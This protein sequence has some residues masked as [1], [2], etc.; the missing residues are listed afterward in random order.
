MTPYIIW[1]RCN[2]SLPS[3]ERGLKFGPL[4]GL[5]TDKWSLPSRERG[6]KWNSVHLTPAYAASLPSRE[7]GLK[8]QVG[9]LGVENLRRSLHGS[10][11]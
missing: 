6:L 2:R 8:Y 5:Q 1:R 4:W 10:V 11:D 3:R 7:R 9:M